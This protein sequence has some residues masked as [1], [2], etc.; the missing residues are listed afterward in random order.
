MSESE[1][2]AYKPRGAQSL[3]IPAIV[4]LLGVLG[5][6]SVALDRSRDFTSDGLFL[7]LWLVTAGFAT[8]LV[9][10]FTRRETPKG[11]ITRPRRVFS[12]G[13][14]LLVLW[15]ALTIVG[16]LVPIL[17]RPSMVI[18]LA[19]APSVPFLAIWF[20]VNLIR[21]KTRKSTDR[22]SL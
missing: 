11:A 6:L 19:F 12:V 8:W 21:G 17:E 13:M 16:A 5:M 4:T 22:E 10:Q 18:Y 20:V 1:N 14:Q 9:V 3:V 2:A 15:I 7:S